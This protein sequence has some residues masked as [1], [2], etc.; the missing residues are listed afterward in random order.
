[1]ILDYLF[2][3]DHKSDNG[4]MVDGLEIGLLLVVACR[5]LHL[6][7]LDKARIEFNHETVLTWLA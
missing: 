1:M 3:R 5:I 2:H 7:S 4:C 6:G